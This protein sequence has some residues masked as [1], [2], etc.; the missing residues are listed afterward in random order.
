MSRLALSV[1]AR[2]DVPHMSLT[3]DPSTT[4]LVLIDL[5]YGSVGLNLAPRSGSEVVAQA[6]E[7]ARA[8]RR[9]HSTAVLV[10]VGNL[11]D[12]RDALQPVAD[13]LPPSAGVRPANWTTLVAALEGGDGDIRIVKRQ[14]GAFYGTELDL[15]LR[16]RG[17]RT[18]FWPASRRT[19]AWNPPRA[20]RSSAA[21]SRSSSKTPWPA[22]R[23]RRTT[24]P[25]DSSSRALGARGRPSR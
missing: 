4:A 12:A 17:I 15:Q 2:S 22:L 10:S 25:S 20:M 24:T 5:Q 1:G 18:R 16:R 8:F 13:A 11:P 23:S 3:L 21:T 7:L 9:A 19:S 14:W 6:A